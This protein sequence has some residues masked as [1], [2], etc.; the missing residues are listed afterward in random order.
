MD[1]VEEVRAVLELHAQAVA[2]LAK[3]E[4]NPDNNAAHI[5]ATRLK[6][7]S[8]VRRLELM[9]DL[10]LLPNHLRTLRAGDEMSMLFQHFADVLIR[11]KASDEMLKELEG[12]ASRAAAVSAPIALVRRMEAA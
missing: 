6:L 11:H 5:G 12:L 3:I 1:P 4:E 2:D 7:E 8:A 9:R 10:G